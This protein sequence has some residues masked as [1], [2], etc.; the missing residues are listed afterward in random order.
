MNRF[1]EVLA[2][3]SPSQYRFNQMTEELAE[4]ARSI[5]HLVDLL[6]RD[7]QS[8]LFGKQPPGGR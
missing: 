2:Q 5:R 3:D 6:E 1:N 4:M 8:I 7:P